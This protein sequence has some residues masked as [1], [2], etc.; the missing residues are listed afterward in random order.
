MA[1]KLEYRAQNPIFWCATPSC[2]YAFANFN[3]FTKLHENKSTS[4]LTS[5][6]TENLLTNKWENDAWFTV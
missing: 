1:V 4:Y 6:L 3:Q 2:K 5:L